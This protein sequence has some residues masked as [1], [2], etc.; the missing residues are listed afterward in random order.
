VLD[1]LLPS[2][3]HIT[4]Q[5]ANNAIEGDHGRLKSR[6]RPMLGL[7][8]LRSASV[9]SAGACFRPEFAPRH[10]ELALDLN[11]SHRIPASFTEC[12]RHVN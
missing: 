6:L 2:T 7:Q 10:Y 8:R 4:E 3:R 12:R 1:E 11:P 5:Y 9:I